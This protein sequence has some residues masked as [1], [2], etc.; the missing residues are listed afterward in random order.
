LTK[1]K[2][3]SAE[4]PLFSILAFPGEGLEKKRA[5][6]KRGKKKTNLKQKPLRFPIDSQVH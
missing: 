4:A 6:T 2:T 1:N 5:K 3:G